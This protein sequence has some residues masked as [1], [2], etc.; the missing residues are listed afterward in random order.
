MHWVE[1]VVD[2][3]QTGHGVH[4]EGMSAAKGRSIW[5]EL[6]GGA[7]LEVNDPAGARLAAALL[8]A[9]AGKEGETC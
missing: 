6:P 7:R 3:E 1:A 8:R 5:V 9:L 2:V 4:E